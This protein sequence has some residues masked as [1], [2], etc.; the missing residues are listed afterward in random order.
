MQ[1]KGLTFILRKI[2]CTENLSR[3]FFFQERCTDGQKAYE[4]CHIQS[5]TSSK[6]KKMQMKTTVRELY[7]LAI[8]F[9]IFIQI[10]QKH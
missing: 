8:L 3:H 2:E 1:L 10:K 7:K 4:K 9:R 5:A 6:V